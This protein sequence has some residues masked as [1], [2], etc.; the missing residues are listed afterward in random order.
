MWTWLLGVAIVV[1]IYGGL[2]QTQPKIAFGA[3]LGVILA[4]FLS[5]AIRPYLTGME[6]LPI[7]LPP[8]PFAIVAITLLALGA[9]I[10]FRADRL[11]PV[12]Q[13]E[14]SHDGHSAHH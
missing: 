6:E 1:L 12:A 13:P 3:L 9:V 4:Y 11:P 14:D 7:W 10:W 2:W 8:L 5:L